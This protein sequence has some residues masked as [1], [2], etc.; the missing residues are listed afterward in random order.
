MKI[1]KYAVRMALVLAVM[2]VALFS[3]QAQFGRRGGFGR[4]FSSP[5]RIPEE[6]RAEQE[7]MEKAI[8]PEFRQ[9]TFTFA[10]LI[11]TEYRGNPPIRRGTPVGR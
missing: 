11:F 10:R 6:H 9:D 8:N 4:R 5:D 2:A 3:A 1:K 7:M